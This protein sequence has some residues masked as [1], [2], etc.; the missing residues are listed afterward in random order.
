MLYLDNCTGTEQRGS[1]AL[2]VLS[3][4]CSDREPHACAGG[5]PETFLS[6]EISVRDER[7]RR[8]RHEKH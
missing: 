6:G 4:P 7:P 8:E 2:Q 1:S 3:H 5:E